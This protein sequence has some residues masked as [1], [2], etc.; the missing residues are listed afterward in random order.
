MIEL[1]SSLLFWLQE[2]QLEVLDM[3]FPVFSGL[4]SAKLGRE[5]KMT[6]QMGLFF[7]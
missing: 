6:K 2:R 7:R 5:A 3:S 4:V 1:C